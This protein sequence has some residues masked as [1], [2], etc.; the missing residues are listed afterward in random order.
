LYLFLL[1]CLF[2]PSLWL[3]MVL[4]KETETYSALLEIKGELSRK[5]YI[6]SIALYG[7]ET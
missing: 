6:W 3:V 5:C 7:A 1:V 2:L 4:S